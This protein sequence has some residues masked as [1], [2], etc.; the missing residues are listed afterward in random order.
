MRKGQKVKVHGYAGLSPYTYYGTITRIGEVYI[1]V[2]PEGSMNQR[3]ETPCSV[4][5]LKDD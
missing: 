5:P 3:D 2:R 4:T 1:R